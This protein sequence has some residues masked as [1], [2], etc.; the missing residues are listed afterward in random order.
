MGIYHDPSPLRHLETVSN[1]M[2]GEPQPGLWTGISLKLP[3]SE[4]LCCTGSAKKKKDGNFENS[5]FE[6]II[7]QRTGGMPCLPITIATG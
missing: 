3:R 4:G 7:S 5:T 6:K 2:R 1:F